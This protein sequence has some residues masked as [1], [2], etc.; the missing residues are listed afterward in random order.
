MSSPKPTSNY[1]S[2][3]FKPSI[4]QSGIF[5]ILLVLVA[6]RLVGAQAS[7]SQT[8]IPSYAT[9]QAIESRYS[10]QLA[11]LRELAMN[12]RRVNADY[13]SSLPLK[14]M[15]KYL[16]ELKT[17][18]HRNQYIF[19]LPEILSATT[20]RQLS[21]EK[22]EGEFVKEEDFRRIE[23][24]HPP[25]PQIGNASISIGKAEL[26]D[27]TIL[28][29]VKYEALLSHSADQEVT[30][31]MILD[32]QA[33]KK[34]VQEAGAESLK[35]QMPGF[36]IIRGAVVDQNGKPVQATV[37]WDEKSNI[38][39]GGP[40]MNC[41]HPRV[42]CDDKG[43]FEIMY[44]KPSTYELVFQKEL[45][46]GDEPALNMDL[47][48]RTVTI[49]DENMDLGE[50]IVPL[51]NI[52]SRY[53]E[54][55]L[56][57]LP[58]KITDNKIYYILVSDHQAPTNIENMMQAGYQ[59]IYV[60]D[61]EA[62][63]QGKKEM[64]QAAKRV[65]GIGM[66]NSPVWNKSGDRIAY[67]DRSDGWNQPKI[68]IRNVSTGKEEIL[69]EVRPSLSGIS[70]DEGGRRIAYKNKNDEICL[71]D[72]DS[73]S[74]I[75]VCS[76][77][78]ENVTLSP[79]SKSICFMTRDSEDMND[80][81]GWRLNIVNIATGK[82][83]K[84]GTIDDNFGIFGPFFWAPDSSRIVF[85]GF[86]LNADKKRESARY[87]YIFESGTM[88]KYNGDFQDVYDQTVRYWIRTIPPSCF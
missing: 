38:R 41:Y 54:L 40:L 22:S 62:Y 55:G 75:P 42:N 28:D 63:A 74:E 5:I 84:V 14:E 6:A 20:E 78:A 35:A 43:R 12:P 17:Q 58:E 81:D 11:R 82:I 13:L 70:W 3:K 29:V 88:R 26:R 61:S 2:L 87:E 76:S 1:S 36:F 48:S 52:I 69:K 44:L 34:A 66:K 46:I 51:E 39:D 18:Q 32:L 80:A 31:Q 21:S 77:K 9:A 79:D 67:L 15:Q 24:G 27:G 64:N 83:T 86:V 16:Q 19:S 57:N 68:A 50:V 7:W 73:R 23:F 10:V 53:R 60:V 33:L 59:S 71:Y 37:M 72:L 8:T 85:P 25:S 49:T 65:S 45:D 56:S 30:C 47:M 4:P